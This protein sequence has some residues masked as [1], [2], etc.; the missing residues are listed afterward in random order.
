[1]RC[2]LSATNW[3]LLKTVKNK[4]QMGKQQS[5]GYNLH[6]KKPRLEKRNYSYGPTSANFER[7]SESEG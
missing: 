7:V 5:L 2:A 3:Q 1:M 6:Y 4:G